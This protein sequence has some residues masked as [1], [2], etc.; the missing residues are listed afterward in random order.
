MSDSDE[1][2]VIYPSDSDGGSGDGS[3]SGSGEEQLDTQLDNLYNGTKQDVEDEYDKPKDQVDAE[4]CR[5][6]LTEFNKVI[7]M[8]DKG[9]EDKEDLEE[10]WNFK[11]LKQCTRIC[12]K[13]SDRPQMLDYFRRLMDVIK[14]GDIPRS[15]AEKTTTKLLALLEGEQLTAI[16]EMYETAFKAIMAQTKNRNDGL[17][18]KL[19]IKLA[20]TLMGLAEWGPLPRIL[21]EVEQFCMKDE[22]GKMVVDSRRSTELLQVFA[23][24]IQICTERKET[25]RLKSLYRKCMEQIESGIPSPKI[26]GI[27]RECGGKMYMNEGNWAEAYKDFHEAFSS[28]NSAG[29]A[30]RENCLKYLLMATMLKNGVESEKLQMEI[31]QLQSEGAQQNESQINQKKEEIAGLKRV[32]IFADQGM[33]PFQNRANIRYLSDLVNAYLSSDIDGFN[34]IFNEHKQEILDDP[35]VNTY[36]EDIL[37]SVRTQAVIKLLKPYTEISMGF[38]AQELQIS[39]PDVEFL[40]VSLILDGKLAGSIDQMTGVLRIEKHMEDTKR[41]AAMGKWAKQVGSLN[42]SIAAKISAH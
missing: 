13:L 9:K 33:A 23:L 26:V 24:D 20:H 10:P 1:D 42:A 29:D 6:A 12:Y 5:T 3:G 17:W 4:C 36:V 7:E 27:I 35:F 14:E 11:A 32:D 28:Y 30:K 8:Y 34:S 37:L 40:L 15:K 19:K 22:G 38:V 39:S 21:R 31:T 41:Y 25:E 18:Y 16:M 2:G